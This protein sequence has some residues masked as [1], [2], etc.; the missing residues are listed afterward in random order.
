[1]A[2]VSLANCCGH[3][4]LSGRHTCRDFTDDSVCRVLEQLIQPPRFHLPPHRAAHTR[5]YMP[6]EKKGPGDRTLVFDTFVSIGRD[7]PLFICGNT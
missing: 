7:S 3:W 4:S 2:A 5:H 1:M 6:W